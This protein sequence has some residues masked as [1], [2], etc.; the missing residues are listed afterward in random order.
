MSAAVTG[1]APVAVAL[2]DNPLRKQLLVSALLGK[3]LPTSPAV[4]RAAATQLTSL[5]DGAIRAS[6]IDPVDAVVM[7]FAET[8]TGLSAAVAEGLGARRDAHSTRYLLPGDDVAGGFDETHSHA[9]GHLVLADALPSGAL[10]A[11]VVVDDELTSGRTVLNL[12][13]LLLARHPAPLV[14]V[15]ALHDARSAEN[16]VAWDA[17]VLGLEASV[18][19]VAVHEVDHNTVRESVGSWSGRSARPAEFRNAPA[20]AAS[21]LRLPLLPG[22]SAAGFGP[23]ERARL[24]DGI[25]LLGRRLLEDEGLGLLDESDEIVVLGTEEFLN[26]PQLLA[27]HLQANA[28]ARVLSS[29]T[30]RSPGLVLDETGYGLRSGFAV[31]MDVAGEQDALRFAYNLEAR[32]DG[33]RVDG[34]RVAV[35]CHDD[36]VAPGRNAGSLV[37]A[38]GELFDRVIVVHA[39]ALTP[40]STP[41]PVTGPAFS[42]YAAEDVAWLLTDLSGH[43]LERPR[44]EREGPIQAGTTHYSENLPI[45]YEPSEAYLVAYERALAVGAERVANLIATLAEQIER[46]HGPRPTL[47]SLA[48][49]GVPVG[50]LLRRWFREVRGRD[51]PHFALSVIRDRGI[52][53]LALDHVLAGCDH[54]S[55]VFVDGWTGKGVIAGTVR[56]AVANHPTPAGIRLET[57][58]AVLSD[59]LGVAELRAT[60]EDVLIPS[61]CLNSTVSG[62][63]S[64]TV[65]STALIGPG[66]YHGAKFYRHLTKADRSEE[67]LRAVQAHFPHRGSAAI[68]GATPDADSADAAINALL[69][70]HGVRHRDLLKPGIGETTRVLL[71]REPQAVVLRSDVGDD[72][73]HLRVLAADRGVPVTVDKAMPF[74]AIGIISDRGA[75]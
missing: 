2:R 53:A 17:E 30:T 37:A 9:I 63:V 14:V 13:R 44:A 18:R 58:L 36:T 50:V 34:S 39:V 46:R 45:E 35:L 40:R 38:L 71:R 29:S 69:R 4:L 8:A 21:R 43:A 57:S 61:A 55:I 31:R 16:R 74:A 59:P 66:M 3:H 73:D 26:P 32:T 47:V 11:L 64:R 54:E 33:T 22:R 7:G 24:R 41:A 15:A 42:S 49:A 27:E 12:V 60:R 20:A 65:L 28:R 51:V 52:D 25:A 56:E 5:V 48:R 10:A 70:R 23:L 68:D 72:L 1:T 6:G 19:L 75:P 67:F 62:L